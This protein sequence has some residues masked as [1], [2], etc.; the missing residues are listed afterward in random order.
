MSDLHSPWGYQPVQCCWTPATVSTSSSPQ[1]L[2]Y[3]SVQTHGPSSSR[4]LFYNPCHHCPRLSKLS[5]TAPKSPRPISSAWKHFLPQFRPHLT[6]Q[7]L[8]SSQLNGSYSSPSVIPHLP[9]F[10]LP[11]TQLCYI[12]TPK[13]HCPLPPSIDASPLGVSPP[14]RSFHFGV[15]LLS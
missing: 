15:L 9:R 4:F 2:A 13:F 6:N 3:P 8:C 10:N 14:E 5:L 11:S 7:G 1:L 12:D